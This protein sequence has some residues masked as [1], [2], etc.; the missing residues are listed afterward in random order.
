[1]DFANT[2]SFIRQGPSPATRLILS[3]IASMALLICDSQYKLMEQTRD[4]LSVLFYPLQRAVNFPVIAA[5]NLGDF[6]TAQRILQTENETLRHQQ[7]VMQT[8]LARLNTLEREYNELRVL[9]GF[10]K[11]LPNSGTL[12]EVL[13]TGRDPF[14]YKIIIDKGLDAHFVPGQPVLDNR[15]LI[16]QITRVQPLT[17]EVTLIVDRSLMVPAMIERTGLRVIMYGYGGG[18]EARYLPIHADVKVGDRLVTSGI[19]GVYPEGI[20]VAQIIKVEHT[21][22]ASFI[23]LTTAP[24][25][26][27]QKE[28]Y[29]LVLKEKTYIPPSPAVPPRSMRTNP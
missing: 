9:D 26:G 15:G 22:D 2:P 16:G 19:D 29:V 13:Y 21:A 20:P 18:I 4:G 27:G 11:T 17:S 28:R 5:R 12:A 23:R 8:K 25:A 3:I 24:Y 14:S 10:N 1:M 7:M 6:F